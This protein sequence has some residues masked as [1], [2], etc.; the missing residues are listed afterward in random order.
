MDEKL[1]LVLASG[2]YP[3][4][5]FGLNMSS[6]LELQY[7]VEDQ[8]L[9]PLNDL[10]EEYAPNFK[11]AIS[12]FE[13]GME[14]LKAVDGNI[15]SLPVL[16]VCQYAENAAKMWVNQEWLDQLDME[17]PT[18]TEEFYQMLKAFKE[19]DMNGNG[20]PDDEL[21]LVGSINGWNQKVET[22]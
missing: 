19:N 12:E 13:N 7:G 2:D 6:N 4:I 16:D 11:A 1:S 8:M 22:S 20:D 18:T 10:I 21:P 3:D 5:F 14:S 15:Y 9:L 17:T